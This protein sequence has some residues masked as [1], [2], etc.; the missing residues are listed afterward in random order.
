MASRTKVIENEAT[1]E[2]DK[3]LKNG[4]N[5]DAKWQ[6]W[7]QYK[8]HNWKYCHKQFITLGIINWKLQKQMD[9]TKGISNYLHTFGHHF[10]LISSFKTIQILQT[11]KVMKRKFI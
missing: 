3:K 5:V 10:K 1:N 2:R 8:N 4:A 6:S 9:D 7:C 11:K